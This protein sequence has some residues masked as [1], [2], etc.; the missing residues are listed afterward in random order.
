M[1]RPSKRH[2][3]PIRM[4]PRVALLALASAALGC[5]GGAPAPEAPVA[6]QAPPE[7][8]PPPPVRGDIDRADLLPILDAGLG[9]FL[10]GVEIAPHLEDGRFVGFRLVSL[11][12]QDP[13]FQGID[14]GPGDVVVRVNGQPIERPEQAQQV[15]N[16][17]RVAS[18]LLIEYLRDG[19][20]HE[21]RFAIVD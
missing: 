21:L 6:E 1:P 3:R 16:S 19:E 13:R 11:W 4:C 15:W 2:L 20:P 9:R 18:A 5:G 17:L 12:P 7:P 14:L 8:P 10:Q